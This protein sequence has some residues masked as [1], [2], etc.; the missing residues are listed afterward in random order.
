[1]L[2][3]TWLLR[4]ILKFLI[5]KKSNEGETLAEAPAYMHCRLYIVGD[6]YDIPQLREVA[7]K[8]F[9][10]TIEEKWDKVTFIPLIT[11]VFEG[12]TA[13]K[14]NGLQRSV[15]NSTLRHADVLEEWPDFTR[16]LE[17]LP[18]FS[19]QL[20]R[21]ML[22]RTAKQMRYRYLCFHSRK[23]HFNF[24]NAKPNSRGEEPVEDESLEKPEEANENDGSVRNCDLCTTI[25]H[26]KRSLESHYVNHH[27]Y[28][29]LCSKY[30]STAQSSR[31]HRLRSHGGI[32]EE[33]MP[34]F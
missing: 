33:G 8:K 13:S 7:T 27:H 20:L 25:F 3:I 5:S 11:V 16:L 12:T 17:D 21:Q 19:H 2:V 1:M 30:F 22:S 31:G 9:L 29:R 4:L 26:C 18:S 34:R 24:N 10:A 28:C 14:D 32:N 6:K 15:L 23:L